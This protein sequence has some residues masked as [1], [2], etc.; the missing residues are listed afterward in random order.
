MKD[1]GAVGY[2]VALQAEGR[3]FDSR[4]CHWNFSFTQTFRQHY[5]LAP[6]RHE[7]QEKFMRVKVAGA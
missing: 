7:Y 3:W 5:G 2:G 6:N 1:G 4:Y